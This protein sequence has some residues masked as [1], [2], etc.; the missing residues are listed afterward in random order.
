MKFTYE[1]HL[2]SSLM[3]SLIKFT[4]EVHLWSSL[5]EFTYSVHLLTQNRLAFRACLCGSGN[6]RS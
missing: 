6:E 3:K 1:V 4:Y 2:S 5:M